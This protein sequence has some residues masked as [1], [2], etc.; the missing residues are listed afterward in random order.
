LDPVVGLAVAVAWVVV[1]A[2]VVGFGGADPVTG[3]LLD[4]ADMLLGN[5][6]NYEAMD[7]FCKR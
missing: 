6:T 1:G 2:E 3:E 5:I 4:T 7:V